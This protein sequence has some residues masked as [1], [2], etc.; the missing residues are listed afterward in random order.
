MKR[1][2]LPILLLLS[3]LTVGAK[4]RIVTESIQSKILG[5]EQKYNVY[6]PDGYSTGKE[7]PVIYLL[8]GLSGNHTDWAQAGRMRDVADLL[9]ARG[10][11][12]PVVIIMPNAGD[13]DVHNYQNGYFNVEGW[14]YEDFFFAEFLPA[15]EAKFRCGGSKGL[16]AIMGLSMGG[17]GSVV[18]A[19]R[20]PDLFSSA[21]GMSAWLD[22]KNQ[23][24]GGAP[25]TKDKMTLTS[26]SVK[27][28]SALDFMDNASKET[29]GAL[30]GVKWFLDC[31][32]DDFLLLLSEELHAKMRKAG[33]K[34]ELR[35]RDGGHTWEY[36]HTA[37]YTALPFASR[38]FSAGK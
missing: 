31:G 4:S 22:N 2:L 15:V 27:D 8:H 38:N 35:V 3:V 26:L 13:Q 36:W 7:Y 6:L 16:R 1:I 24:V 9:I 12:K 30:K 21:Y 29:I 17:G 14:P 34:C 23:E 33:V 32:D 19:Q 20:H 28:H 11:L 25:K 5:C 10:E 18:Y 37:L